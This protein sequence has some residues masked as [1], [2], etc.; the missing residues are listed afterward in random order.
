MAE[1][2]FGLSEPHAI[3]RS[4]RDSARLLDATCGADVVA[5]H[6]APT[7]ERPFA[8]EVGKNPG[9]LRIAFTTGAL[10]STHEMDRRCVAAVED[11]ARLCEELG[12]EVTEAAPA[13]DVEALTDAFVTLAIS[14]GALDVEMAARLTGSKLSSYP[15]GRRHVQRPR[16]SGRRRMMEIAFTSADY[17]GSSTI[18]IEYVNDYLGPVNVLSVG[19]G[20]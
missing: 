16:W 11:A 14:G 7:P 1:S 5:T 4:V 12:H 18:L 6:M 19:C 2:W 3:T 17:E 15:P 13:I 8:E 9:R 10:L 20:A